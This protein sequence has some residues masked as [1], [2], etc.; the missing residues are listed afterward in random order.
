MGLSVW[1]LCRRLWRRG[2]YLWQPA[3]PPV[4]VGSSHWQHLSVLVFIPYEYWSSLFRLMLLRNNVHWGRGCRCD[5]LSSLVVPRVVFVTA[6]GATGRLVDVGSS[7]WQ[8]LP[9]L[10]L[11]SHK[12][13]CWGFGKYTR[14]D[15]LAHWPGTKW[16]TFLINFCILQAVPWNPNWKMSVCFRCW[17]GAV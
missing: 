6:C 8:L 4:N 7:H 17:L 12:Y 13:R 16:P 10:I 1:R 3:V 9:V 15:I 11:V 2:L 5:D 14:I